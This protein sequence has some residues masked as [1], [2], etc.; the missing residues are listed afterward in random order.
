MAGMT[1]PGM[2][3]KKPMSNGGLTPGGNSYKTASGG[4]PTTVD[5]MGAGW[6]SDLNLGQ[7]DPMYY[8]RQQEANMSL[9]TS[10]GTG[11]IPGYNTPLRGTGG[12]VGS[13]VGGESNVNAPGYARGAAGTDA[14]VSQSAFDR[15]QELQ[16]AHDLEM[17]RFNAKNESMKQLLSQYGGGSSARV[18]RTPEDAAK[19]SAARDAA[20]ARAKETAGMNARASMSALDDVV[21]E[22]GL[23]GSSVDASRRGA[24]VGGAKSEVNDFL[25][26]QAMSEADRA[27]EIS[28][29]EYQGQIAQRGQEMAKRQAILSL[30]NS[31]S[32]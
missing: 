13:L 4:L 28:D 15:Q 29:M 11:G 1:I 25:R 12:A 23:M 22:S 7:A 32:Y 14:S 30:I 6:G 26:D 18:T 3:Q 31:M 24:V 2:Q 21:A 9:P 27:S 20:F 8:L 19:E 10:S 16:L 17:Q 5:P